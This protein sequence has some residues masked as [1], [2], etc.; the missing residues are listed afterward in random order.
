MLDDNC[1][2]DRNPKLNPTFYSK[3]V[4]A[5]QLFRTL[6]NQYTLHSRG[7]HGESENAFWIM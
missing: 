2:V 5:G 7:E 3:F 6:P 4:V 1:P